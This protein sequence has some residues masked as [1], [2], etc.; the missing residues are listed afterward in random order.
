CRPLPLS[1]P[2]GDFKLGRRF[3]DLGSVT[4]IPALVVPNGHTS[5]GLPSGI[6]FIGKPWQEP[7]LIRAG[8]TYEQATA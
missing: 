2:L 5:E 4:G 7:L 6:Q 1:A 3:M 8:M